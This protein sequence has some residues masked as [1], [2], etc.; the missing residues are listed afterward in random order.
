M[1]WHCRRY[2]EERGEWGV[3]PALP[4]PRCGHACLLDGD[5]WEP[6]KRCNGSLTAL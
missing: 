5:R 4:E 6:L 3:L 2:D 1:H